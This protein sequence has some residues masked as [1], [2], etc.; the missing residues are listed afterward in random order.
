MKLF[1]NLSSVFKGGA[2]QVAL[3]FINECRDFRDNDFY[4]F[5]CNNLVLQLD[6]K[7]FPQN[8]TFF[9][10]DERPGKSVKSYLK[11][12]NFLNLKEKELRP[13]CVLS[14]SSHGYWKPKATPIVVGFNIP[15]YVYPES[16]YFKKLGLTKKIFWI[17][18]KR[19]HLY[20]YNRVD[21]IFVQTEDVRERLRNM[22]NNSIVIHTISNTVN[23]HYLNPVV[24]TNKIAFNK[25]NQ[26]K[27]LTLSAYYPHKNLEIIASVIKVLIER[28]IIQF[29]FI[30]T[31]P[32][33]KFKLLFGDLPDGFISN[34]GPIPVKECPSLY[35]ECDVMFLPTLLECFSAS[36]AEAM[37][38]K[39]P[40]ITSD[41]GFAQNVCK[42]AAV[43]FDPCN[44]DDIIDKMIRVYED[45]DLQRKMINNG[46]EIVKKINSANK[47]A[48]SI[49]GI[50]E[51]LIE[52]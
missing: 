26:Y 14:T 5:L 33:E 3:S 51:N 37:L 43:Y 39:K 30:V 6:I 17:L 35:K 29:R 48:S 19:F 7:S 15:H 45:E 20:F 46:I 44:P 36:Y 12:V 16:P 22:V 31:L 8:F 9:I 28:K 52:K 50:C 11:F 32:S 10:I 27:L 25:E 49:L 34:I 24:F 23:A 40:I 41:L 4:V 1:V 38:M 47:R 13:D 2:E 42:D 21:A 18:K